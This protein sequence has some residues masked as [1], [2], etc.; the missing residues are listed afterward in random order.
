MTMKKLVILLVLLSSF[1]MAF[2]EDIKFQKPD[3]DGIKKTIQDKD[4]KV[5]Y[6]LL[7]ERYNNSDTTLTQQEFSYLYYGY[8]F[9]DSYSVYT[10]PEYIDSVNV[11]LKK[12][13][14]LTDDFREIVK[15]EKLLLEDNPF[16]IRSLNILA[17]CSY[18]LG[19]SLT[20]RKLDFKVYMLVRAI[21]ATGDGQSEET[22]WHILSVSDEYSLIEY[23]DFHFGGSQSLTTGGCDYLTVEDNEYGIKGFYFDVNMIL[24]KETE[25]FKK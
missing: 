8:F 10:S 20:T 7:M 15:Y 5:Y 11:I 6:P 1:R 14:L 17:N 16:N 13:T 4:S 21:I 12:D 3:Y 2:S 19:D 9:S 22:A 24:E 18:R 25:L 23:L